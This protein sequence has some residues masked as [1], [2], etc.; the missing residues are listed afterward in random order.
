MDMVDIIVRRGATIGC[1]KEG[2]A[3]DQDRILGKGNLEDQDGVHG[4]AK[5]HA[6][7]AANCVIQYIH[8]FHVY[9]F[10]D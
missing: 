2:L 3:N 9:H 6:S 5:S 1:D 10:V 4:D 8:P 7:Y